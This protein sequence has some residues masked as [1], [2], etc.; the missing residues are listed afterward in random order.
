MLD[1]SIEASSKNI[2]ELNEQFLSLLDSSVKELLEEFECGDRSCSLLICDNSFIQRLNQQYRQ[3]NYSTDVLSFAF[4]D[5]IEFVIPRS[6]LGDIVISSE[7]ALSQS[8]EFEVSYEEEFARLTIHGVLHLLGFD[9]ELGDEEEKEMFE[10][11]DLYM[12]K[13]M[14]TYNSTDSTLI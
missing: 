8:Q 7:T 5:E 12:Q 1:I 3:K 14:Q 4:D 9:H 10:L 6:S 2:I 13:F 11:Q